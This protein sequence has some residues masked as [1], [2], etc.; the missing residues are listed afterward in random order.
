[1]VQ[2]RKML[3]VEILL[4]TIRCVVSYHVWQSLVLVLKNK[5]NYQWRCKIIKKNQKSKQ[6]LAR[7]QTRQQEWD[8]AEGGHH[9]EVSLCFLLHSCQKSQNMQSDNFSVLS[10]WRKCVSSSAEKSRCRICWSPSMNWSAW[11]R[12]SVISVLFLPSLIFSIS[13]NFLVPTVAGYIRKGLM[14]W[15]SFVGRIASASE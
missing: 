15:F 7:F 10:S 5:Q 8:E 14:G 4:S 1:M 12:K 13:W 2:H 11:S 3:F 6:Y 9:H